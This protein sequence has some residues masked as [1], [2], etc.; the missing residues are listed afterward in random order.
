VGVRCRRPDRPAGD[1]GLL[2]HGRDPGRAYTFDAL[3]AWL[4][5]PAWTDNPDGRSFGAIRVVSCDTEQQE[6]SA[7]LVPAAGEPVEYVVRVDRDDRDDPPYDGAPAEVDLQVTYRQ[8]VEPDW[9]VGRGVVARGRAI[10]V[11]ADWIADDEDSSSTDSGESFTRSFGVPVTVTPADLR[12]WITGSTFTDPPDGRAFGAVT[13]DE[14]RSYDDGAFGCNATVDDTWST[15]EYGIERAGD[16]VEATLDTTRHTVRVSFRH[17]DRQR[18]VSWSAP[19]DQVDGPPQLGAGGLHAEA[20]QPHPAVEQQRTVRGAVEPPAQCLAGA[21]R[22]HRDHLAHQRSLRVAGC[23]DPLA[24]VGLAGDLVG[25][26][27]LRGHRARV[28]GCRPVQPG[29]GLQ[30]PAARLA[31]YDVDLGEELE[32][33]PRRVRPPVVLRWGSRA[34]RGGDRR[35]QDRREDGRGEESR[36]HEEHHG[37]PERVCQRRAKS[38]VHQS[39]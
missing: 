19:A 35:Q 31:S 4:D 12:A 28:R 17:T 27:V 36:A 21:H 20:D 18:R 9:E 8:Y 34:R 29:P 25:H 14:C 32:L 15:D 13:L 38:W 1:D 6:C 33:D 23:G 22:A 11:P 5:D 39:W 24:Q 7:Q 10:P 30:A 37:G 16:W 3:R 2:G 26:A